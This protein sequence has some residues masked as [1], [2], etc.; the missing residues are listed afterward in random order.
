MSKRLIA[1]S[2]TVDGDSL[3]DAD[4]GNYEAWVSGM[5][6][7]LSLFVTPR[8]IFRKLNAHGGT[9]GGATIV[10]YHNSKYLARYGRCNALQAD[11]EGVPDLPSLPLGGFTPI[12]FSPQTYATGSCGSGP[13]ARPEEVL[14]H[15]LVHAA[16][17][18]GRDSNDRPLTGAM[19]GYDDEEE[20]FAVLV[21]NIYVSETGRTNLRKDHHGHVNLPP[22]LN[23]PEAFLAIPENYRLIRT[24]CSQH[25]NIA[26]MIANANA[27]FNPIKTYYDWGPAYYDLA[28][29]SMKPRRR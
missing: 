28:S 3:P 15:E 11:S 26:P 29:M 17:F 6:M 27:A 22:P 9:W 2:I 23:R 10:P 19:S 12:Y 5:L 16:R 14:L 25:P 13:A 21:T 24:F 8:A 20:F 18:L 1:Y 7:S 4:Q